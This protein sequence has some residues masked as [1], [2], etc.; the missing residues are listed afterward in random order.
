[1]FQGLTDTVR[2]YAR[3]RDDPYKEG[4]SLINVVKQV[5]NPL[6]PAVQLRDV[7][8]M[9]ILG[10]WRRIR[11]MANTLK[12]EQNK[13]ES[14]IIGCPNSC[15]RIALQIL[16]RTAIHTFWVDV[17]EWTCRISQDC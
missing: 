1:M 13:A 3:P 16:M 11:E 17:E 4:M 6:S 2:R 10:G 12:T 5:E 8:E 14:I 9:P 7:C 15:L